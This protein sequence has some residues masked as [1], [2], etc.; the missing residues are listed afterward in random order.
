MRLLLASLVSVILM[1]PALHAAAPGSAEELRAAV[2]QAFVQKD[3]AALEAL[4]YTEGLSEADKELNRRMLDMFWENPSE[5]ETVTIVPV[6]E[7]MTKA[8]IAR[9]KKWEPSL[10]PVGA[11]LVKMKASSGNSVTTNGMT[12]AFGESAGKY[13]LVSAKSTDLGWKGP[14]DTSLSFMVIGPGQNKVKIRYRWNVSGVDL[15]E[16]ADSPSISFVGQYIESIAVTSDSDDTDVTLTI[17][18]NEKEI[19]TS[20]PLKGKGTLEYKRP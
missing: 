14:E 8:L 3:R 12:T 10:A 18:E 13:Y 4:Y 9:G 16:T 20:Q 1:S 2:E 17:R 5:T 19:Y 15:E 6:P 11:L 7:F